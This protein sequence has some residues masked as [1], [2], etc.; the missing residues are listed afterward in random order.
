MKDNK[1][2]ITIMMMILLISTFAATATY[3]NSA[4]P[5]SFTV[6]VTNPPKDLSLSLQF[7]GEGE[8]DGILLNKEQKAWEAYYRFFYHMSPDRKRELE[9]AILIVESQ[10]KRFE[11]VL[12]AATFNHYNNLLTLDMDTESLSM[13]QPK[14]RVSVLV[15]MRVVLTLLIE[16]CIFFAFGYRTKQSWLTFLVV[17]GITQGGLNA[18]LTGPGIGAYWMFGF[19]F[20][21]LVILALELIAFTY[22]VKEFKKSRSACYVVVANAMS[23]ILGGLLIAYLPV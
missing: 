12:P 13:G 8:A 9:G 11:C 1:R 7:Q 5:P 15:V 3:A 18:M 20:G 17:N 2:I 19:V 4:E 14:F 10:E 22:F 6:M 21:E 23:L 16:G